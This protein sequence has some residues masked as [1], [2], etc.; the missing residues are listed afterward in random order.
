M[1]A[2]AATTPTSAS[3]KSFLTLFPPVSQPVGF[4]EGVRSAEVFR[5]S[6]RPASD[7][8]ESE[9]LGAEISGRQSSAR[10]N[11]R[12]RRGGTRKFCRWVVVS[13]ELKPWARLRAATSSFVPSGITPSIARRL[14]SKSSPDGLKTTKCTPACGWSLHLSSSGC[15]EKANGLSSVLKS[16]RCGIAVPFGYTVPSEATKSCWSRDVGW[17]DELCPKRPVLR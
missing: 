13:T 4:G 6:V 2:T 15:A 11:E 16:A 8:L 3:N 9:A 7:W 14:R 10:G 5:A 17:I 1:A 12:C